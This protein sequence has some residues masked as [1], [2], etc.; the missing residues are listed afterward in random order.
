M[1]FHPS[2]LAARWLAFVA[3]VLLSTGGCTD[4]GLY[5]AGAGG[6]SGPD[7]LELKGRVCV[8]LAT[9]DAFPVK[10]VFALQGGAGMDRTAVGNIVDGLNGVASAYATPNVSFAVVA[11]HAIATG[12]L[13]TFANDTRLATAFAQYAAYQEGGPVSHRG[14]LSL[15]QSLIAGDMTTGCKGQV[16]RTRYVVVLVMNTADTACANPV[17]NPGIDTRCNAFL[18]DTTQCSSCELARVTEELRQLADKYNAGEVVVQ[19]VYVRDSPDLVARYEASVIARAGGSNLVE[20][21]VAGVA[22]TLETLSYAPLQRTLKLKRL[23][24]LNRNTLARG[25]VLQVDSDGDGLSDE[26]E[27]AI[28]TNPRLVDTDGDGLSDGVEVKMGLKPVPDAVTP[29]SRDV[30][31]ACNVADDQDGDRLNDCEERVLGTDPCMSDTDGDGLPDLVEFLSATNP[32]IAEDLADDDHDGLS[33][34]E[35][36]G[37]AQRPHQRR[38]RLPARARG[39]LRGGRR[40]AHARRAPLLRRHRLQRGAGGHP[41]AAQPQ[42]Q[43]PGHPPGQQRR[44]P[45]LPGGARERPPRHRHRQPLRHPGEVRAA[46]HPQAQGRRHLHPRRLRQWLLRAV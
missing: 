42:R 29:D 46:G 27:A 25:G 39:G 15:A 41:R 8:P 14:P 23:I 20:T 31:S 24:A 44:V 7:R 30:I 12:L 10:V 35:E 16:A 11:Y 38:H 4:A 28:G 34:V 32:L 26:Q 40:A 6:P 19:P 9:G 5:A 43:R 33:N 17:F 36:V 45:L 21:D 22:K 37:R 18:P 2:P 13:G 3:A 1:P